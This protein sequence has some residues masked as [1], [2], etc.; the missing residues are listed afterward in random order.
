MSRNAEHQ[1]VPMDADALE[2]YAVAK[3]EEVTETSAKPASPERLIIQWAVAM[4]LQE[5]AMSNYEGNQNIPSRAN[6]ENLDALAELFYMTDRPKAQPAICTERFHISVPQTEAILIPAGTRV[7]DQSNTLTWETTEDTYISPGDIHVDVM[8]KCQTD[9]LS[10]NGYAVGQINVLVD[11]FDYYDHCENIT[12][13]DGGANQ[14]SDDEFYELM[15]ASMDAYSSAG[16][17]GGYVYY[18]KQVSTEIA[19]VVPNSPSAG[20]VNIYVLMEGGTIAG[21]EVKNAV[22]AACNA[23]EVRPLTDYV[24]VQDPEIVKYNIDLTYYIQN[25]TEQSSTEIKQSVDDA[26]AE[27]VTWQSAKLGRDINPDKLRQL[28]MAT[29]I[30]RVVLRSPNFVDLRDGQLKPGES[31]TLAETVPQIASIE[32]ITALN[33]GYEDE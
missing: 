31:Y 4:I 6:G 18:A 21:T 12:V 9:G 19:D 14:A 13:S 8:V 5:R 32:T 29:G 27:Y 15:R 17:K 26:I 16:A 3:Y 28:L 20:V 23:D 2:A 22:L 1:F 7:T 24:S 33:G 25:G 11:L 10:G 30:K